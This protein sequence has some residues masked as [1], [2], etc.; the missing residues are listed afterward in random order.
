VVGLL[1]PRQGCHRFSPADPA[2]PDGICLGADL[3][4]LIRLGF[5][6]QQLDQGNHIA[7]EKHLINPDLRSQPR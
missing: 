7:E 4:H 6:N 2:A 3:P 1:G 5:I